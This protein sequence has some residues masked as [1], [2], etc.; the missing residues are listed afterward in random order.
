MER[1]KYDL[2]TNGDNI[3]VGH[4]TSIV[5]LDLGDERSG[6]GIIANIVPPPPL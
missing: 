6:G 5:P 4:N 1:E 3:R 2:K